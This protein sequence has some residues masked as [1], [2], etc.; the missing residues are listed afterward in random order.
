MKRFLAKLLLVW[1]VL[2]MACP[3]WAAI[4]IGTACTAMTGTTS[5]SGSCT[6][7]A[8]AN[9]AIICVATRENGANAVIPS[10]VTVGGAA[11]TAL[12]GIRDASGCFRTDLFYK[13]SPATGSQTVAVTSGAGTDMTITGVMIFKGV[14]QTSTFNTP[15]TFTSP[16]SAD[17]DIDSLASAVGE[18]GVLCGG[19]HDGGAVSADVTT[20]VSTEQFDTQ[21]PSISWRGWGYTEAGAVSTIN[22]RVT[23]PAGIES[24]AVAASMRALVARRPMSP[25]IF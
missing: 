13:L 6:I 25:I 20:P 5:T 9:I 19:H 10:A 8:D 23:I 14:A 17:A 22:M 24:V 2:A 1:L 21:C 3:A 15:G 7:D 16:N 11:A 18:M 4:I 12:S